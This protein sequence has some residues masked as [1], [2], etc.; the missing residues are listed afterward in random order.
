M[1]T[2]GMNYEVREGKGE[3]FESVFSK[4]LLVMQAMPGHKETHLYRDVQNPR[5]Y[6]I[7]SEWH[8]R[9]DFD[10][11][12]ASDRFKSVVDWG[13]EEVL[14]S[15]PRHEVYGTDDAAAG[16]TGGGCPVHRTA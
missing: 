14:A 13:R 6:L 1:I 10:A 12:I 11:F 8:R 15:R 2:V 3:L 5:G 16:A 7:V 4:V 9:A